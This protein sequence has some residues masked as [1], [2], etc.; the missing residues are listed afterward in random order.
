MKAILP[1]EIWNN[2]VTTTALFIKLYISYDDLATQ[3]AL[4]YA[5]CDENQSPIVDGQILITGDNYINWGSASDS[6]EEAYVIATTQLNLTID[7][8]PPLPPTQEPVEEPIIL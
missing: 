4:H 2:G 5:L 3:A 7:P 8:N 1:L 6:N